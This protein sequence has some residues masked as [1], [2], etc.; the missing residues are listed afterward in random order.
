MW[1]RVSAEAIEA[2]GPPITVSDAGQGLPR[3]PD[4]LEAL[5][6]VLG[7]GRDAHDVRPL[8]ADLVA[9]PAPVQPQDV[10]RDDPDVDACL[11]EDGP[12]V[13]EPQGRHG[14]AL[15]PALG[16]IAAGRDEEQ[17]LHA[18]ALSSSLRSSFTE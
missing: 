14:R 2:C 11:F 13:E 17:D 15:G 5:E 16:E 9:D 8:G 18:S 6:P 1:E 4:E 3:D 12:D 10:G 7:R